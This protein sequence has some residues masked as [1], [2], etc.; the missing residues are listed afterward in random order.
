MSYDEPRSFWQAWV[1]HWFPAV[2]P[3]TIADLTV[4]QFVGMI[5]FATPKG[6]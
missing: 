1:G 5:D 6:G 4:G 3:A 2:Q